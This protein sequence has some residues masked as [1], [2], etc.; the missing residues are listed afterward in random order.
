[1]D[2]LVER[3]NMYALSAMTLSANSLT[4][5]VLAALSICLIAPVVIAQTLP[6]TAGEWIERASDARERHSFVGS[7]IYQHG[8]DIET[9]RIWRA[10]SAGQG[11]RERLESLSG[12][13]REILRDDESITCILPNSDSRF[14]DDRRLRR[15]LSSRIPRDSSTLRPHYQ[16]DLGAQD[17]V[18]GRQ[19][20]H[21][22]LVPRDKL[23]YGYDLWFDVQTGMLVR[24]EVIS[25]R[26]QVIERLMMLDFEPRQTIA[27][28]ELRLSEPN[29]G[30]ARVTTRTALV[31]SA[32]PTLA[33]WVLNDIPA[34]FT[35]Q[36]NQIEELPGRPQPVR[37]LMYSDGLATVSIYIEAA[38][39]AKTIEGVLQMG[40][41][42]AYGRAVG[43]HQAIVVGEVPT[44]TV[45]RMA[46]ALVPLQSRDN[47][48]N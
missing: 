45:E 11:V 24:A 3:L 9:V 38:G 14:I 22:R 35:L 36:M 30:F 12:E 6:E 34:G 42:N 13:Y 41:M 16:T 39:S 5:T 47:S 1:M 2:G 40:A 7:F 33:N 21:V 20:Q 44:R 27:K 37:H 10:A 32:K 29:E 4:R 18:A 19:A 48:G 31:D 23:R 43:A 25:P 17:R 28:A 26:G 8:D 46:K 15:T